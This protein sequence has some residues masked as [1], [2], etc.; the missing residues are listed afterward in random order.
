MEADM[1]YEK[2]QNALS[3]GRREYRACLLK[4]GYPY[5]P[6]LDE[7]LSFAQVEYEVNLGV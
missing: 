1:S 5:L 6:A 3:A 7:T 4:G 2:Y